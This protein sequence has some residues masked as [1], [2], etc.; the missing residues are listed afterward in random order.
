MPFEKGH[1][2]WN[3]NKK[4]PPFSQEW[5]DNLGKATKKMWEDGVF[6]NR[7]DEWKRK[8][9]ETRKKNGSAKGNKNPNWQGG[10]KPLFQSIRDCDKYKEW[11]WAV[12]TRD[13]YKCIN[14]KVDRG[15]FNINHKKPFSI[16]LRE[17]KISSF[18]D[19]LNCKELWNLDNGETLCEKCHRLTDTYGWKV[20]NKY[21]R[22]TSIEASSGVSPAEGGVLRE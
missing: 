5:K 19:A 12:F 4:R 18:E 22:K 13:E 3:T 14:C 9:S 6:A 17:N 15:P 2:P 20:W 8:I 21:F 11:W 1:K 10:L 16:I 7:G